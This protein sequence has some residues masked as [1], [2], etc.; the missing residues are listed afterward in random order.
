[1]SV[2]AELVVKL[3]K[4]KAKYK[5]LNKDGKWYYLVENQQIKPFRSFLV[6][7]DDDGPLYFGTSLKT[8]PELWGEPITISITKEELIQRLKLLSESN[9]IEYAH[10]EADNLLLQY[11][12]DK[13]IEEAWHMVDKVYA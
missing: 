6:C 4:K 2:D 13:E 10:S 11:I 9:D 8:H 12:N 5:V 3:D 1:M 7:E